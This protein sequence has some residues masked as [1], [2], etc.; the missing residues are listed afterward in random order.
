MKFVVSDCL[1]GMKRS[2]FQQLKNKSQEELRKNLA[3]HQEKLRSLKFDLAAG[4]VKNINEIKEIKKII[5]R[6]MTLLKTGHTNNK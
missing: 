3:E 5:A 4:K 1:C 2:E 6:I